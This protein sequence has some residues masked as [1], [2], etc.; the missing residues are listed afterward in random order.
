MAKWLIDTFVLLI[1]LL[2]YSI[3]LIKVINNTPLN[4]DILV[5][6]ATNLLLLLCNSV[7][8]Y[9]LN[10]LESKLIGAFYFICK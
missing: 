5:V 1:N 7:N 6:I 4:A 3:P 2:N 10:S 9:L 8:N